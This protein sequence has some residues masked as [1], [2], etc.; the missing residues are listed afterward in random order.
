MSQPDATAEFVV[1]GGGISGL[2]LAWR[3]AAR[4]PGQVVLLEREPQVGGL[5]AGI[6]WH[7][8]P[9]DLGSHRIHTGFEPGALRTIEQ[10]LAGDL[11]TRKRR[12]RILVNSRFLPY[13]PSLAT[14]GSSFGVRQSLVFCKDFLRARMGKWRNGRDQASFEGYLRDQVGDSLYEFFYRPYAEKLWALPA[15][16]ISFEPAVA[17]LHRVR[18]LGPRPN[19]GF[20]HYPKGGMGQLA[21]ALRTRITDLGGTVLTGAE[22]TDLSSDEGGVRVVARLAGEDSARTVHA[23][24]C[25]STLPLRATW[26]LAGMG[27]EPL[28][29]RWRSLR[30]AYLLYA[31]PLRGAIDTYYF[32]D[33]RLRIGRVSSIHR[34]SPELPEPA[35]RILTVEIPCSEAE[36][37]WTMS[38]QDLSEIVHHELKATGVMDAGAGDPVEVRTVGLRDVYPVYELGWRECWAAALDRLARVDHLFLAGRA[39]LF[40]HCNIDHCMTMA[41][42]LATL[43]EGPLAREKWRAEI[44]GFP[45]LKLKE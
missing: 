22:A 8:I 36:D 12:G 11:R 41:Q 44:N 20:F 23:G 19:R 29:L 28:P 45:F 2:S 37:L 33:P 34:F 3:L 10:L 31:A 27:A 25:I 6:P 5:A 39:A 15:S 17:R 21:E 35:N 24:T 7:G 1:L 9:L 40:L 30:V 43:V 26:R 18:R 38:D 42:R 32:P 13:P 4:H 14:I 16:Q